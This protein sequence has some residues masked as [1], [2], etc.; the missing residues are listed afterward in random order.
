MELAM[1]MLRALRW[2]TGI[3]G[4]FLGISENS[5]KYDFC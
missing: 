3:H 5:R 1:P 4:I 2:S